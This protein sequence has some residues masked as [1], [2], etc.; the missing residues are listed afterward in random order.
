MGETVPGA[1]HQS[2]RTSRDSKGD[3]MIPVLG[4]YRWIPVI[5]VVDRL[6]MQIMYRYGTSMVRILGGLQQVRLSI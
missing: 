5:S 4:G 1:C 3:E 2:E 6:R